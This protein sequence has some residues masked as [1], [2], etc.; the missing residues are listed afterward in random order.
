MSI[1]L[2]EHNLMLVHVLR[3]FVYKFPRHYEFE[4][5]ARS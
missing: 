2:R 3:G 5:K 1:L 4:S